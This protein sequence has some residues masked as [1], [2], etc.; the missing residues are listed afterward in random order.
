MKIKEAIELA[1]ENG[2]LPIEYRY[3]NSEMKEYWRRQQVG[4][5][6]GVDRSEAFL[7]PVFWSSL[8]KG[9]GWVN[10]NQTYVPRPDTN[11]RVQWHFFID[12]LAEGKDAV[13]FFAELKK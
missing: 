5:F 2:W 1:V 11:W 6:A 4:E 10:S 9:L 8:G 12:H 7:D 13:D 3:E